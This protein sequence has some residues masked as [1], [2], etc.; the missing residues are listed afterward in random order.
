MLIIIG[1]LC[2]RVKGENVNFEIK[3][4]NTFLECQTSEREPCL[5]I[6]ATQSCK[7]FSISNRNSLCEPCTTLLKQKTRQRHRDLDP[8]DKP[9]RPDRPVRTDRP[10]RLDRPVRPN[11]PVRPDRPV[12]PVRPVKPDSPCHGNPKPP[13]RSTHHHYR[14]YISVYPREVH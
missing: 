7:K 8:Y 13:E 11:R 14:P 4:S 6:S 3:R 9:V 10:V 5:V 1:K 12:K 2:I